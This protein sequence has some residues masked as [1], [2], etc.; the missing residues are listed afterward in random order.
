MFFPY[1]RFYGHLIRVN[2]L[3]RKSTYLTI[4]SY[5]LR[6]LFRHFGSSAY[7]Y[8]YT[9]S[10]KSLGSPILFSTP[11]L[12]YKFFNNF[13]PFC[14]TISHGKIYLLTFAPIS[15]QYTGDFILV[16][17]IALYKQIPTYKILSVLLY[18]Y[19]LISVDYY[20]CINIS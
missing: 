18:F 1:F 14:Q 19:H 3:Q 9:P 15:S 12:D 20:F 16:E 11:I 4:C 7:L 10:Q 2:S 8:K 13:I 17:S 5:V 6:I